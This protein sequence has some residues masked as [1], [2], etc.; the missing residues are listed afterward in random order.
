MKIF[1]HLSDLTTKA[2][3]STIGIFSP[4]RAARY[5]YA[6]S[7]YRH[8]KTRGYSAAIRKGPNASWHPLNKSADSEMRMD[9]TRVLA[10]ARDLARNNEY[11]AGCI[12]TITANVIGAGITPQPIVKRKTGQPNKTFNDAAEEL[13]GRWADAANFYDIQELVVKHLKVDGEV[14]IHFT[15]ADDRSQN[16]PPLRIQPLECDQLAEYL[17]GVTS[18]GNLIKRGVELDKFNNPVAYHVLDYH[19]GETYI[20]AGPWNPYIARRIPADQMLHIFQK[21]RITQTRGIS[22]LAPVILRMYDLGEYQDFEMTGAK[23]AAAFGVFIKSGFPDTYAPP[24]MDGA[25]AGDGVSK[26]EYIEPGR[27]ERLMPGEEIQVAENKRPGTNYAPFVQSTLRG[28]AVGMG[29]SYE[30]YSGD[31]SNSTYSSARSA[32][33]EERRKYRATQRLICN[34][35]NNRVYRKFLEQAVLFG[36]LQAPG[37]ASNRAQYEVVKWHMPGWEWVDPQKDATAAEN[38]IA[39]GISTRAKVLAGRGEDWDDVMIQLAAEEKRARELGIDVLPMKKSERI[40]E[41]VGAGPS[42]TTTIVDDTSKTKGNGSAAQ[43]QN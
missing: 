13:F 8:L 32:L 22:C 40:T 2:I 37:Y 16:I 17:D 6:R 7:V 9:A 1:D 38:E 42:A 4:Y 35:L 19:P 29:L 21:H 15:I 24:V 26:L 33:L 25:V 20:I 10:R 28:A 3:A 27:I 39:I 34:Q 18:G 36:M 43:T 41:T 5:S 12:E 23:L 14:L 31:Y 30:S 11:G